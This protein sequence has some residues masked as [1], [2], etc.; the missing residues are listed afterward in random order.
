RAGDTP[1]QP[2]ERAHQAHRLSESGRL[3]VEHLHG[4]FRG[5]VAGRE[6]GAAGRDHHAREAGAQSLEGSR[7]VLPPIGDDPALDDLETGT[8]QR[9]LERLAAL[10]FS[11]AGDDA[12]GDGEH[13]GLELHRRSTDSA[14]TRM[15]WAAASGSLAPKMALPATKTEAPASATI[16]A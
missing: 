5:E 11:R 12:V 7:H 9:P 6:A 10:V 8:A 15:R 2:A 14:A 13:L 3:S 1:R 4:P 16:G